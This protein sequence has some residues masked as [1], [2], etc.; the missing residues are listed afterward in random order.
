M[1]VIGH[2]LG[3]FFFRYTGKGASQIYLDRYR[4]FSSELAKSRATSAA[5]TAAAIVA[6]GW[7][8]CHSG[9]SS[10]AEATGL[11]AR[12]RARGECSVAKCK[13]VAIRLGTP[14]RKHGP[15]RPRAAHQPKCPS[16]LTT[17]VPTEVTGQMMGVQCHGNDPGLNSSMAAVQPAVCRLVQSG[18]ASQRAA[19]LQSTLKSPKIEPGHSSATTSGIYC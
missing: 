17:H 9:C 14:C 8:C 10:L 5:T 11:C 18:P 16:S 6:G 3:S 13:S 1:S 19:V 12:H 7:R 4:R 15:R 2:M